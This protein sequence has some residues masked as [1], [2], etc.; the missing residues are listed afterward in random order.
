MYKWVPIIDGSNCSGCGVCVEACETQCLEVQDCLAV[1]STPGNCTS[2]E[3][4]LPSC[5]TEAIQ[6]HWVEV[7]GDQSVGKWAAEAT[8]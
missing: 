6:M 3:A 8:A 4:C 7:E 2:D 1:L 5:P